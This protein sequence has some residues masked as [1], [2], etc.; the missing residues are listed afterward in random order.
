MKVYVAE[1]PKLGRAIAE[2]LMKSSPKTDSGREFIAG[3]DWAVCW[4]SGHIFQLE[5]PDFYIHAKFAGSPKGKNGK[6]RWSADHLPMV[7]GQD[8]WPDWALSL[9]K[10]KASL[11]KTIK[12]WV[13]K[14]TVVV[15]AG[16]PD[17][18]GQLLVDEILEELGNRKPVRRVLISGFDATSVMNGLRDERDNQDPL[19]RGM[20]AAA[21]GRSRSDWL[22]GMNISRAATLQAQKTGFGGVVPIGRVQTPLLGL[23]VQRDLDIENFKPVKYF[24]LTATIRV[25][26]GSFK[27]KWKPHDGQAGLDAEGR[28][29]DQDV[30]RQLEALV[31]GQHGTIFDYRDEEK[32]EGPWL[33]FSVDKIQVLASRKYGYKSDAVLDALQTLYEKHSLTTYPRSDCQYLPVSQLRDAPSVVAAVR[34]NLPISPELLAPLD[35]SRKSRAWN[36]SKV[37][38]HHAIVPTGTTA[39]LESLSAIERDIYTEIC[40]RY[41]A[42]FLPD[43]LYRAVAVIADVKGQ[44]FTASGT[45][46]LQAGW[47]ALYGAE[48]ADDDEGT[49]LPPITRGEAAECDGLD[50][51]AKQ[52]TPPK[53]FTDSTLLEAMVNIHKF[54][55]DERIKAIFVRMLDSKKSGDEEGSCGLGTPATRHTFV[56]KLVANGFVNWEKGK[57]KEPFLRSTAQGRAL[58]QAMPAELGKP[59][60]TALWETAM[61]DMR[62]GGASIERFMATQAGWVQKMLQT[63]WASTV[64]IP[65]LPA[66]KRSTS[67]STRS[68]A[69]SA[70]KDCPKCGSKMKRREAGKGPF[71]GCSG[72]PNCKHTEKVAE[73][74]TTAA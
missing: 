16:D 44:H 18:E 5:E 63:I 54:V 11:F 6:F 74:E 47:K 55:T 64:S 39:S 20:S 9:D 35:L 68:A 12:Q 3:R 30:A 41:L 50:V 25:A 36:D 45:T 38:A 10:D 57:G 27:T 62:A 67:G 53:P 33:P 42:Q 29:L 17:D 65:A 58:I 43:R 72:Y 40:K 56:P 46:T 8:G 51:E 21:R 66:A 48:S 2:V 24:A 61:G 49:A 26:R 13:G 31:R 32:R 59:D 69:V 70:G 15:N 71:L 7:P 60:M 52:T 37:T 19:F 73:A 22:V 4:A 28:L 34:G 14:A 1:K 23:V